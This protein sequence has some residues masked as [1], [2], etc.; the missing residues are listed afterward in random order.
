MK[1]DQFSDGKKEYLYHFC[2]DFGVTVIPLL[3]GHSET[4]TRSLL[5]T[6]FLLQTANFFVLFFNVHKEN[7]FTIKKKDGCDHKF[8]TVTEYSLQIKCLLGL[9]DCKE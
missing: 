7:V 3:N 9:Q 8:I 5:K 6:K 4:D 2:T 1:N